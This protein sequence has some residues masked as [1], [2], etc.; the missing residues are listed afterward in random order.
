MVSFINRG[1]KVLHC[2]C[3]ELIEIASPGFRRGRNDSMANHFLHLLLTEF[4]SV[5]R[6]M[7]GHEPI[8]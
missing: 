7:L 8:K 3:E 1:R 2:H 5:N 6:M 4:L